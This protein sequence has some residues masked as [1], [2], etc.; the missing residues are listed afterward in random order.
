MLF[1]IDIIITTIIAAIIITDV[2]VTF[3]ELI[4][5]NVFMVLRLLYA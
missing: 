1:V 2:A 3:T 4:F 5:L